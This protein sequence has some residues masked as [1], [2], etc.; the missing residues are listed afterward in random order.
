[1]QLN[2]GLRQFRNQYCLSYLVFDS[3]SREA[4]LVDPCTECLEQYH[5]VIA[6]QRL[7]PVLIVET[8]LQCDHF[9]AS[10][11]L[12]TAYAKPKAPVP[13]CMSAKTK[14]KRA[15]QLL[16]HGDRLKVGSL[17]F[18]VLESA[19]HTEDSIVLLGS[20]NAGPLLA[21]TGD[22][23]LL[24]K[25][26]C[27]MLTDCDPGRQWAGIR[28]NLDDLPGKT[29]IFPG[30][31]SGDLLFSLLEVE[32]KKNPAWTSSLDD[33]V[34]LRKPICLANPGEDFMRALEFNLSAATG[35]PPYL[36][37]KPS[38]F[39]DPDPELQRF[40]AINIQKFAKKLKS[41]L[42]KGALLLDVREQNE[43]AKGH[44]AGAINLPISELALH[45]P[46]IFNASRV[47]VCGLSDARANQA[48][49]T[50]N[51]IGVSD[52]LNVDGGVRAWANSGYALCSLRAL[53]E[54]T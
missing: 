41:G 11:A 34:K 22:T 14:S 21:F 42:E 46:E 52:V 10:Q 20:L 43:F 17:E 8:H 50:L 29:I 45:L 27:P 37:G 51:Y 1:M 3:G 13:I 2:L 18:Q 32:K 6:E 47:Y 30:H 33:F 26:I 16:S 35:Q 23:L 39:G 9:S 7:K 53:Q 19:D 4:I 5:N 36:P 54:G 48:V 15:T 49:K 12:A 38:G 24:G 28:K 31:D 40:S 25:M 44:I